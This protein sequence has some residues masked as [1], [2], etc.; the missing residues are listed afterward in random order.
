MKATKICKFL[1][2]AVL[3]IA[4]LLPYVPMRASAAKLDNFDTSGDFSGVK[5]SVIGD[6]ISTYYGVT[7]S[8]T[9]NPLYKVT[10]EATFGTYYGNTS[11]GDYS[12][13]S[14][15]TRSDTWWQQIVDTLGMDLLVNNA[16]SGSY[17]LK[18]TAQSNTTEYGAAGY[19][20]RSVNLHKGSTNP[21]IIAVYLGTND[22]A[23]YSSTN[24]GSKA[25]IDTASERSA[26]Y[27]SVNSFSTPSSSV[28]AYYIMISRMVAKYPNAEIY[29]MLPTICLAAMPAGRTT[30]LNNLNAG[31]K[32]IVDY[33]Q[34]QGKKVYL[35]DLDSECDIGQHD[36][37]ENLYYCNNVHPNPEGMDMITSCV[38]NEILEH[39][40]KG[41]QTAK[42]HAITT[43]LSGS[44]IATGPVRYG[45]EGK[46]LE[47]KLLPYT[48]GKSIAIS[49]TMTDANTGKTTTYSG[50]N[51]LCIPKV[52]G[53]ITVNAQPAFNNFAWK[54]E[55]YAPA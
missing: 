26:L 55:S 1:L 51:T 24:V 27:K 40:T 32:Y 43:N 35:V 44:F 20:D 5:L 50:T 12:Q 46:P 15:V 53:P 31:I 49:A 3:C 28:A 47:L 54:A 30:A 4:M 23:T 10:S 33:Y 52:T 42:K 21:D 13:F 29:C 34:S 36:T 45:I 22:V 8:S 14:H 7:N 18:D 25:D 41:K 37:V 48:A 16:W 19:K 2:V 9:Y 6:S 38:I 39:S 11:H 17:I